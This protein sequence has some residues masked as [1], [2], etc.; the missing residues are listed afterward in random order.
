[1]NLSRLT[2]LL[3]V[4]I[5]TTSSHAQVGIYG[6]F[7]ATHFSVPTNNFESTATF[8]GPG[9]GVYYDFLHLGP[10]SLGADVRGNFLF[11][12]GQKYR[13][14]LAGLRLG[15]KVPSTSIKPYVQ[16]SVGVGGP[17]HGGLGGSGSIYTNKFEYQVLGGVDITILPHVD[18]R[19]EL[20][21]GRVSGIS[22]GAPAPAPSLLVAGTG[23]VVRF[24]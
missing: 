18:W 23:F 13:S 24:L 20:G 9:A 11:G 1:M 8:Y 19:A 17:T 22:S 7:D 10:A 12:G 3:A 14:V 6:K 21:Y 16:G 5:L 15:V 4:A 2:L